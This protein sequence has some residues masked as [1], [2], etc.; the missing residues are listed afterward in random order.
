MTRAELLTRDPAELRADY[1]AA[2]GA[3]LAYIQYLGIG[4]LAEWT[5]TYKY[6]NWSWT[7]DNEADLMDFIVGEMASDYSS[8]VLPS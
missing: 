4:G 6:D 7:F 2:S 3:E 1:C 5:I 8:Q